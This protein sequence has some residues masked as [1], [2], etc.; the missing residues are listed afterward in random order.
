MGDCWTEEPGE[1][2]DV[3]VGSHFDAIVQD[4]Q[5]KSVH[6]EHHEDLPGLTLIGDIHVA[7]DFNGVWFKDPDGNILHI[8]SG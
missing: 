4:L 1:R 8:N 5:A 6:F 2:A 3:G 7:D